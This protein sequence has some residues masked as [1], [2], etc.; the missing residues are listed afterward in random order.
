MSLEY[1]SDTPAG[2]FFE[3]AGVEQNAQKQA[4]ARRRAEAEAA[5]RS[6]EVSTWCPDFESVHA[7]AATI[8]DDE[9]AA[10][11]EELR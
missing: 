7:V 2:E 11:D 8:E 9:L 10:W 1:A 3:L 4:L 5:S 6:D